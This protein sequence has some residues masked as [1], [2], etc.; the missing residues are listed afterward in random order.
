MNIILFVEKFCI[1]QLQIDSKQV[2]SF[3]FDMM[4][5]EVGAARSKISQSKQGICQI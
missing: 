4:L 5:G 2:Y 3:D 1:S